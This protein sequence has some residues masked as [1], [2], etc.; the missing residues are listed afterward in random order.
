MTN[1]NTNKKNNKVKQQSTKDIREEELN[2]YYERVKVVK[3]KIQ[4]LGFPEDI[5]FEKFLEVDP[6]IDKDQLRASKILELHKECRDLL[7]QENSINTTIFV[8]PSK[9]H[10][11]V[12]AAEQLLIKCGNIYQRAGKIV[13]IFNISFAPEQK[14]IIKRSRDS[15]IIREID[16]VY[17]TM[18]LTKLGK[19]FRLDK[20]SNI[21]NEIDC[22]EKIARSLLAKQQWGLPILS[23]IINAPTLR[24]DGTILD[25][26]GY[27]KSS[28]MFFFNNRCS[29]E[30][31]PENPTAQEVKEA[32]EIL[33]FILKDFPFENEVSK[34]VAISAIFTAL[35]RKS[36]S[37]APL[38]GFTAP[39]M[40]SGKS[41]LADVIS[42]IGNGK[43][44]SVIAQ[45]E[46]DAEEKK[47][48]L[49]VLIEGDP[50]VCYDNI[51][52]PFGSA[53][54]CAVLTQHEYKDRILGSS[55]TRTVPTN[56]TFL[57][58]GN[59]LVFMGDIST[60]TLL[61]KLDPNVERPEERSFELNLHEY[62]PEHRAKLIRAALI[63]LR[64]FYV[65][66]CPKQDIKP[67]GRFEEWSNWVRSAVIWIKLPDPCE[68]RKDIEDEDPIRHILAALLSSWHE[69]FGEESIKL[70]QIVLTVSD[71]NTKNESYETLKE[72][73]LELIPN[74]KGN[75]NQRALAKKLLHYKN[76]I[77]NGYR[78]E[79]V[80]KNQGTSLWCVK[81]IENN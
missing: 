61:C 77:E 74:S 33:L 79:Q 15:I 34:S 49:S 40:G 63:I 11:T 39:K 37:S 60:R 66:G 10:E 47:R 24:P 46:T 65:A 3:N 4:E 41:L 62:I 16:Q 2:I 70:K 8:E 29:F 19:F 75:I 64:A 55:E 32:K 9:L 18:L 76:R 25:I 59:N 30:K 72:A 69:I 44:N 26:P 35:I 54:L 52:K 20:R 12:D 58:T 5:T 51:E 48:L 57:A 67:F 50:I 36:I 78:I 38:F 53:A 71:P 31:I 1:Y 21:V 81:K 45:A 28:G 27:D 6:E 13:G 22:P 43:P 73:I 7:E 80:G 56:T 17:L 23:G 14:T 68:S 42:L